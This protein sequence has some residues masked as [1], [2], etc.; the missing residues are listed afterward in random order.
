MIERVQA[1]YRTVWISDLHLGTKACRVEPLLDFLSSVTC[2]QLY[3]VGDIIDVWSLKRRWHWP[4]AHERVLHR[5]L[6]HAR[7]GT[8]VTYIPGNHD[9]L[10]RAYDGLD[11]GGIEIRRDAIHR[12]A[13]DRRV[14]I[15]HGDE[16]DTIVND[17]A[18]LTAVGDWFYEILL[19][20]GRGYD[21][22]RRKYDWPYWSP[23][24][25]AKQKVKYIVNFISNYHKELADY[26]RR[27]CAD[28]V[29]TGHIHRPE[30]KPMDELTYA[31]GPSRNE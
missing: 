11:F 6:E 9:A 28:V 1:E 29:V 15:L 17:H 4:V 21:G 19:A 24:A 18:I 8:Q 2:D 23:A 14:L 7:G 10:F 16:F 20:I 5:I 13:D 25:W 26:A 30:I 27:R 12:T 22:I 3:L 31:K